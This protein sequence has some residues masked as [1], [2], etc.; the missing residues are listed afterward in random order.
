MPIEGE[1]EDG[2]IEKC[3]FCKDSPATGDDW[4]QCDICKEWCHY[5]C[6]GVNSEQVS[7]IISYHCP[8]CI[9]GHGPSVPRRSSGRKKH[10]VDYIAL[11]KGDL[12]AARDRHVYCSLFYTRSFNTSHIKDIQGENLTKEWAETTGIAEPVAIRKSDYESLDMCVP[13]NLTVRK[14]AEFLGEGTPLDVM[15]VPSQNPSDGWTLGTWTEYFETDTS[16][17]DRIR[18]VISLEVSGTALGKAVKRPKF[19]RDM[20]LVTKVWPKELIESGDYPKVSLYCLMSVQDSYTDFHID[21]GGSSVFYHVCQGSKTF[22]F[23]PPTEANLNKY[24]KW[25]KSPEQSTTFFGDLTKECYRVDLKKGDSLIIPSGWIHAVHTPADSVVIGGN[26]LTP[27][28]IP[29]Q[30]KLTEIEV[31]TKVP[32][33]FR[34]P[35]FTKVLWYAVI[36]YLESG[37]E[38]LSSFEIKGMP[39]LYQY[40]EEFLRTEEEEFKKNKNYNKH[41][42]FK[43]QLPSNIRENPKKLLEQFYTYYI[44]QSDRIDKRKD[45]DFQES[46][47]ELKSNKKIKTEI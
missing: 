46:I 7:A 45:G 8:D 9:P 1:H 19:V 33:K 2:T 6:V 32:K 39:F 38:E 47:N 29:T 11:D 17:R 10:S 15:D 25:C 20:D 35:H 37:Q 24:E 42:I 5:G 36:Y 23:I 41:K 16:K 40:L 21:F 30:V 31:K 4:V 34:F 18:N 28:N 3:V 13:E 43:E 12:V 27:I 22:L 26:F 44:Q 14:V